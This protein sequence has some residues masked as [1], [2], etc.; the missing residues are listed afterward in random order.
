MYRGWRD[1]EVALYV[2][3]GG[4][5]PVELGVVVNEREVLP[6]LS[7]VSLHG[8]QRVRLN[9]ESGRLQHCAPHSGW[10]FN[11]REKLQGVKIV[12]TRFVND[13]DEF[14]FRDFFV[15][16]CDI[17]LSLFQGSFIPLVVQANHHLPN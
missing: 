17:E 15:W 8:L 11:S 9:A 13:S 12:L 3:L 6:L 4:G 10:K 7:R 5:V 1:L 14:V 16:K 2:R